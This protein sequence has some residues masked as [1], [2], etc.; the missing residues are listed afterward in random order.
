MSVVPFF[1]FNSGQNWE[2]LNE[3]ASQKSSNL[4]Y[5]NFTNITSMFMNLRS[6]GTGIVLL[7]LRTKEDIFEVS[8]YLSANK[9]LLRNKAFKIVPVTLTTNRAVEREI[10]KLGFNEVIKSDVTPRTLHLKLDFWMKAI[11]SF[12]DFQEG[13]KKE[14]RTIIIETDPLKCEEDIWLTPAEVK[15][16]RIMGRWLVVFTGPSPFGMKWIPTSKKGLWSLDIVPELKEVFAPDGAWYFRGESAP[17]FVWTQNRWSFS[18]T[19]FELYFEIGTFRH[20]RVAATGLSLKIAKNS[21]FAETKRDFIQETFENDYHLQEKARQETLQKEKTQ[22]EHLDLGP[23][24]GKIKKDEGPVFSDDFDLETSSEFLEPLKGKI[25]NSKG[26]EESAKNDLFF[27]D[28]VEI[29]DVPQSHGASAVDHFKSLQ[30][31]VSNKKTDSLE[32]SS[33]DESSPVD[34]FRNL[35]GKISSDEKKSQKETDDLLFG[36]D[37]DIGQLDEET[38]SSP[39]NLLSL[40]DEKQESQKGP[41]YSKND[42]LLFGDDF[43]LE[44]FSEDSHLSSKE[45]EKTEAPKKKDELLFGDDFEPDKHKERKTTSPVDHFKNLEGKIGRE[46]GAPAQKKDDLLFGDDFDLREIGEDST[47][48]SPDLSNNERPSDIDKNRAVS[49]GE[50]Q[51]E[52]RNKSSFQLQQSP[53]LTQTELDQMANARIIISIT[54]N[55]KTLPVALDDRIEDLLYIRTDKDQFRVKQKAFADLSFHML[56]RPVDVRIECTIDGVFHE[57]ESFYYEFRMSEIKKFELIA[58]LFELRQKMINKFLVAAAG[59]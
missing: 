57:G 34:H 20:V 5:Q 53:L 23:L 45:K 14:N 10:T 59:L 42:N 30:G 43:D 46:K 1:V 7:I 13:P 48:P 27:D 26:G 47:S 19:E 12:I 37:F 50:T 41:L 8:S 16:K 4:E 15:P 21:L 22:T 56:S 33:E 24:K 17:E 40:L 9:P 2:V 11:D 25:D 31:K 54:Q 28:S 55:G 18:G 29:E 3:V 35:E 38:N 51:K 58:R 36:D 39:D 32:R 49:Q 52:A 44:D 6:N